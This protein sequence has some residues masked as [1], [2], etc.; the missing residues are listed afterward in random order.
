MR[1]ML[2]CFA[3]VLLGVTFAQAQSNE[4]QTNGKVC[5]NPT[6]PCPYSKWKFEANDISFKL[7]RTLAWQKNYYSAN[8]YAIVLKSK[9]AIEDPDGP[10]GEAEC[11]GYYSESERST[12]QK[13]FPRNKV[14]ASRF[15]CGVAGIGYTNFNYGYNFLAVY[16]G[17]T[18]TEA[19]SFLKTVIAKGFSD[20]YIRKTQ[21]VLGYGD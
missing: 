21:V 13:Q 15:G 16:A 17:E 10:A 5:G 9:R 11:S 20:A 12:V 8:F 14:F 7:P 19:K 3:A 6:A 4:I 2:F 1:R 18:E